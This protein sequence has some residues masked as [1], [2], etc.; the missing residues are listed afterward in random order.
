MGTNKV[1]GRTNYYNDFWRDDR[2]DRNKNTYIQY[3]NNRGL[4]YPFEQT[5][6]GAKDI[7]FE[8]IRNSM[9][10]TPGQ[11]IWVLDAIEDFATEAQKKAFGGLFS[12]TTYA[13]NPGN[14]E[15][16]HKSGELQN[17][18]VHFTQRRT[19]NSNAFANSYG[20]NNKQKGILYARKHIMPFSSS[21]TPPWQ[22]RDRIPIT[23]SVLDNR[24]LPTASVGRG[25]AFWDAPTLQVNTRGGRLPVD[26]E[27]NLSGSTP[28]DFIKEERAVYD[29]YDDFFADIKALGQGYSV[30][31]EFRI[32]D[33]LDFYDMR[34]NDS[35][36]ENERMLRIVGTPTGNVSQ[37][38]D[39]TSVPGNSKDDNFPVF[40]NSDFMKYFEVIREDHEDFAA[41][42]SIKLNEGYQEVCP[43]QRIYP[44]ERTSYWHKDFRALLANI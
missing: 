38:E 33:H 5:A 41:P 15:A 25:T 28:P 2:L 23:S 6:Q 8:K 26:S 27:G 24:L 7:L 9:G 40:T 36:V 21:V 3:R 22:M 14:N 20:N 11:S 17:M 43:I 4:G 34:D 18:Y 13:N 1:R 44:A 10:R 39:G 31:P 37:T 42:N 12:S 35:L 16:G 19:L 29:R 32:S 30:L